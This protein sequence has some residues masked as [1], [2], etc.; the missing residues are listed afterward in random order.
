V[1]AAADVVDLAEAVGQQPLAHLGRADA[2]VAEDKGWTMG[3]E[4]PQDLLAPLL[5]LAQGVVAKPEGTEIGQLQLGRFPH[6]DELQR[7]S[8]GIPQR[9]ASCCGATERTKEDMAD[10]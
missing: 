3:I 7:A 9:A 5:V 2:V 6:I 10:L 8:L 4:L 1:D